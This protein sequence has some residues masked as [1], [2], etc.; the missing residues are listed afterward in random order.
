[1][2]QLTL[3]LILGLC[4][5]PWATYAQEQGYVNDAEGSV[6]VAPMYQHWSV[7]DSLTLSETSAVIDVRVPVNR[8]LSVFLRS[9]PL[10][11]EREI[12]NQSS[13][14]GTISGMTDTQIGASYFLDKANLAFT[15]GISLPTG[16][17]DLTL[18]EFYTG[19]SLSN[20]IFAF[21]SPHLGQG[22]KIHPGVL[23]GVPI[24][25]TMA[26]G[27]GA[28]YQFRGEYSPIQGHG[29]YDPG[30]EFLA[31]AGL[32][33]KTG[34]ASVASI[35]VSYTHFGTDKLD[36][37]DIFEYG[38][39]IAVNAQYRTAFGHDG[40]WVFGRYRFKTASQLISGTYLVPADTRLEPNNAEVLVHYGWFLSRS[41]TLGLRLEGRV[42]ESTE[43]ELS[44][45]MLG[46]GWFMPEFSFGKIAIP[47][48][49]G[50]LVGTGK[51]DL[52]LSSYQFGAGIRWAFL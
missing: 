6:L 39:R 31:I 46:G 33:F 2:K 45:V 5:M 43:T 52:S 20:R 37:W 27:I 22:L 36:G 10:S 42:Y 9:A 35:D 12:A 30:D 23:W 18:D 13:S 50:G 32:D 47:V 41:V 49:I 40:L 29:A 3:F 48:R 25:P 1:M 19:L 28:A 34:D 51:D 38:D 16:Q 26:A 44:G 21:Q 14:S 15:L 17:Q 11:A 7:G 8:A 24:S 4:T